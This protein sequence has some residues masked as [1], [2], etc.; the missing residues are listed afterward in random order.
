MKEFDNKTLSGKSE[1]TFDFKKVLSMNKTKY[2]K[3]WNEYINSKK[4]KDSLKYNMFIQATCGSK[5]E[6]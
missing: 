6:V 4:N 5:F 2:S 1:Y 3:C